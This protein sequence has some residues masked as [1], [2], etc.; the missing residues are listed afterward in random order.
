MKMLPR[1]CK[2]VEKLSSSISQQY[3]QLIRNSSKKETKKVKAFQKAVVSLQRFYPKFYFKQKVT[4]EFVHLADEQYCALLQLRTEMAK[5]P[6]ACSARSPLGIKAGELEKTLWLSLDE[7][8]E[9]YQAL[10]GWL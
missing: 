6:R 8:A 9:Q 2:Q 5:H 3:A 7:Y 1:L 4:E 10:K